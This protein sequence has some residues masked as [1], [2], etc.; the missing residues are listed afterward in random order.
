MIYNVHRVICCFTA[1]DGN[2][3]LATRLIENEFSF[4]SKKSKEIHV[5]GP[6]KILMPK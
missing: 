1:D 5:F 2:T 3:L 4:S 6:R